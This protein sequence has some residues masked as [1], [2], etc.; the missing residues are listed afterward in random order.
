MPKIKIDGLDI[1]KVPDKYCDKYENVCHMCVDDGVT[2]YCM[3]F[4][5]G[6]EEENYHCKRLKI[7]KQS[8]V[9]E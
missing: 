3:L 8:E 2:S 6:L 1:V 7:C 9:E 4:K 5:Y